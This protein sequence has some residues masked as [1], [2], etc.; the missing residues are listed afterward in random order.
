MDGIQLGLSLR[1]SQDSST[2]T[3]DMLW[4]DAL[5]SWPKQG[6]WS[7]NGVWWTHNGS[8]S[9]ND[10]DECSSHLAS[11][12]QPPNDV[13]TRYFLSARAAAGILRRAKK[14]E[15]RLPERLHVALTHLAQ[16]TLTVTSDRQRMPD[17][18]RLQAV[19]T[20]QPIA[21]SHTQGLDPQPSQH[22]FPTLRSEGGGQAIAQPDLGVR[23][24]TPTECE[25]LM[26]WPDNHT[27]HRADGKTNADS[28]RYKMC[29]NGIVAPVSRWI[30][31]H[32]ANTLPDD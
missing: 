1:T 23:R 31:K 27:L 13:P 8:E 12:L 32:L 10:G 7:L 20:T 5:T 30:A 21:F 26:G 19:I 16:Q 14:R 3:E 25:R 11:I 24:L 18:D 17:K 4:D 28:T 22:H 15:K 9:P 2:P 29:G 6:R